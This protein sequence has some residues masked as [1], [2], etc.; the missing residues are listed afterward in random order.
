MKEEKRDEL[1]KLLELHFDKSAGPESRRRLADLVIDDTEAQTFYVE[2]CQ[3]HAML[4]WEHGVMPEVTFAEETAS[5]GNSRAFTDRME[6]A[7]RWRR[8][9]IAACILLFSSLIWTLSDR[10]MTHDHR[11][12]PLARNESLK[13]SAVVAW[14]QRDRVGMIAQSMGARLSVPEVEVSLHKGDIARTGIYV[15]TS[16]LVELNFDR[17]IEVIIES[18]AR[19]EIE[20]E[21]RMVLHR[22]SVSAKVSP[23]G[24]GFAIDTP[25]VSVVDFGTEFGIEVLDD[26][27]S[28]VH[29]FD[30]EVDVRP[31]RAPPNTDAVRLRSDQA[32]RVDETGVI[33]QGIDIDHDR[34]IRD[35]N[36]PNTSDKRY[37]QIVRSLGPA[38]FLRMG[39]ANDGK[40]L[41]GLGANQSTGVIE[42]G[43]M[44]QPPF[45]S[46][47]VG[48]SLRFG[49]PQRRAYAWINDYPKTTTGQLSV[50][51]WVRAESR[52]RWAAIAKHWAVELVNNGQENTGLGGQFH[53]GLYDDDG[54][55]EVQVRDQHGDIVGL[56]E[57]EPLPLHRWQHVA[58]VADGETL[59]L[60]R[61]GK[62]VASTA[63][64]GIAIDGPTRLGIAA[65]LDPSGQG[66]DTRN[67]G[68][69]QG[70]IDELAIFDQALTES[71]LSE[72]FNSVSVR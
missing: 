63:C 22:G 4:A 58:F 62:P 25:S 2:Q 38:V 21:M 12:Q 6:S 36:E 51:A 72:L 10:L 19:F 1:L 41:R 71:Q 53:F 37:A 67:P 54:D 57:R 50:C 16:G 45:A 30:G 18:P 14:S 39:V 55:L 68:F 32:T 47:R 34:F 35:L 56:R 70:R 24:E 23:A 7:A 44:T 8:I 52:T 65:K 48:G 29:V 5:T 46:G 60:Y 59:T 26:R 40:T 64:E 27:S 49:G 43:G 15:L 42:S 9:A 11:N 31:L 28:E 61:N 66:P 13:V 20:S 17:G 69:W 33:P 3:L